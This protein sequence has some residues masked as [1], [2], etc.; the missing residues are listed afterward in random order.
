VSDLF[1]IRDLGG[2]P[3]VQRAL[4]DPGAA[5]DRALALARKDG[6]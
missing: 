1:T 4:F 5:Y 6:P 2:W 3:E